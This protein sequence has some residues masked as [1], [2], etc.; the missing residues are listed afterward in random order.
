V[1]RGPLASIYTGDIVRKRALAVIGLLAVGLAIVG[2]FVPLLPTTPFLLLAAG[3]F[4]RSSDRLYHWL[5]THRWL[6][7]YIRNYYEHQAITASTK[8]LSLALLWASIGYA[9][10]RVASS[11]LLRILLLAVA[12]GVTM[13]ILRLR[14]LQAQPLA[15]TPRPQER[16]PVGE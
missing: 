15:P 8:V 7:P 9:V 3:C 11:D 14:T 5:V 12:T 10:L 2:V 13:H 16:E 6:G 1:A 4:M